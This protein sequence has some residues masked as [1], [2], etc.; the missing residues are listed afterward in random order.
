MKLTLS[1]SHMTAHDV[2]KTCLNNVLIFLDISEIPNS[3]HEN[4]Y[5]KTCLP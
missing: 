2:S 1:L 5:V 4:V 3:V